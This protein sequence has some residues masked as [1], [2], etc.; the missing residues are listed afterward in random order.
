MFSGVLEARSVHKQTIQSI[1]GPATRRPTVIGVWSGIRKLGKERI[2]TVRGM[3][4][5]LHTGG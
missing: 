5:S 1:C 4:Y 3:G 2:V